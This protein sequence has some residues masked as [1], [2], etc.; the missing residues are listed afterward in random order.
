[1]IEGV[2]TLEVKSKSGV[3]FGGFERRDGWWTKEA[4]HLGGLS[5]PKVTGGTFA[6]ERG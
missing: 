6:T 2:K 3:D 1:M 5:G 4:T